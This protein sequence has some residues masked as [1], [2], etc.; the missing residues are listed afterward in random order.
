MATN[1]IRLTR[2]DEA[3]GQ[4]TAQLT[5]TEGERVYTYV[6]EGTYDKRQL[7]MIA[8]ALYEQHV[9]KRA[10]EAVA[11]TQR[12]TIE[13][14]LKAEVDRVAAESEVARG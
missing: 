4:Y 1:E 9:R 14:D 8:R 5:V 7:D 12:A 10:A 11:D 13:A 6:C 3:T 2:Y